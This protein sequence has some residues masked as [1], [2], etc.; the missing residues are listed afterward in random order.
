MLSPDNLDVVMVAFEGPDSYSLAGGLGVRA[1]ELTRALAARGVRTTLIF[2]GD[3]DLPAESVDH[4]VRL[5]R[6]GQTISRRHPAGVYAGE[7]EKARALADELPRWM[8]RH[9]VAP[10][11]ASGRSVAVLAEEWHTANFC[12]ALSDHLHQIGLRQRCAILWNA[13]N[14]FGFER[15]NWGA[16]GYIAAITTVSR[17]MKHLMWPYGVNATVIPNGIPGNALRPVDPAAA[18]AIRSAAD[19]SCLT[20][21]RGRWSPDKRWHQAVGAVAQLRGQGLPTR[22]LIRGGAEPFGRD[23]LSYARGLGLETVDWYEGVEDAG[24]VVRALAESGGAPIVNFCRF[25]PDH[26]V[27]EM[28]V[29]ATAVLANSGHEPFGLVGLEAMAAGAVAIVGSTG[30]EY[31]RPYGNSII[32]ETDDPVEVAAALR[33]LVAR[34]AL[35][36]RLRQTARRDAAD[37]T[38]E[39]VI[40]GLL[41]RLRFVCHHQ[42]VV[43]SAEDASGRTRRRPGTM[44]GS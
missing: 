38:W 40:D 42:G 15:I 1:R 12:N 6:F 34:P 4:G 26:V 8:A 23:V 35:A 27:P 13:N 33:G 5:I 18:R 20:V 22:M 2:V 10:A 7:H 44:P 28:D 41:E 29:A 16:L 31:A 32:T 30:E 11:A 25:L 17:Y 36:R 37:F 43:V 24:G 9:V 3:P 19:A 14:T 21:K 39:L